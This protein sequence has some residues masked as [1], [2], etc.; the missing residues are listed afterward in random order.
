VKGVE[1]KGECSL[2]RVYSFSGKWQDSDYS[3]EFVSQE[4]K[5]SNLRELGSLEL[6]VLYLLGSWTTQ[7]FWTLLQ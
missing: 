3:V 1:G 6:F 5:R 7:V 4:G 2:M